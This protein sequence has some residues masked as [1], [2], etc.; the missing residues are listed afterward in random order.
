MHSNYVSLMWII[1]KKM[2]NNSFS[3]VLSIVFFVSTLALT[4]FSWV[5]SVYGLDGVQSLLSAEGIRW[6]LGHVV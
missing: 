2:K 3:S 1:W 5:G 4:L 6:S